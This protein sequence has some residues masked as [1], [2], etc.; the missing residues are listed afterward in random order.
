MKFIPNYLCVL[1]FLFSSKHFPQY[2]LG[3]LGNVT[4][5]TYMPF[6]DATNFLKFIL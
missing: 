4:I 5:F 6:D 2:I 1:F 3:L